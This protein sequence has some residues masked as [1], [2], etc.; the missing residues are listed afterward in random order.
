MGKGEKINPVEYTV[1]GYNE[2][3][4]EYVVKMKGVLTYAVTTDFVYG[5]LE[6]Y[7]YYDVALE[8]IKYI[9][10]YYPAFKFDA[11]I[12]DYEYGLN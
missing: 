6:T 7:K 9:K 4:L 10:T 2:D 5:D 11:V 12:I 1:V 3:T 8:E